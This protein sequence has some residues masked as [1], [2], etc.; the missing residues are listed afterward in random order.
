[1]KSID[2]RKLQLTSQ[3]SH[4]KKEVDKLMA[5]PK[6]KRTYHHDRV[7]KSSSNYKL[8]WS[9]A[10]GDDLPPLKNTTLEL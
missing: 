7:G 6:W 4:L 3:I 9:W 8:S 10:I 1:M 5:S 2:E